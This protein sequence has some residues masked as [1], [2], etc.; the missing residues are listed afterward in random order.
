MS[1]RPQLGC[2]LEIVETLALTLIWLTVPGWTYNFADGRRS[3]LEVYEAVAAE[4][5]AAGAWYYGAVQPADVRE[6]LERATRAGA[7]TTRKK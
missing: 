4:A 2:L 6:A 7:F 3:A 1:Q 5:L